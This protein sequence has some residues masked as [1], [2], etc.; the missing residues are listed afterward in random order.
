[1][2][3]IPEE[4]PFEDLFMKE[5][6]RSFLSWDLIFLFGYLSICVMVDSKPFVSTLSRARSPI[7]N[8][9]VITIFSRKGSLS[10]IHD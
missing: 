4:N 5:I 1:V 10:Y 3:R 6:G 8:S 2:F 9:T 7:R